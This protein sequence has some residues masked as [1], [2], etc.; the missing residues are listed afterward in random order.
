[1]SEL[2]I[3]AKLIRLCSMML[4]NSCS[5]VG[6]DLSEPFETVRGFRQGDSLSCDLFNFLMETVLRKAAVH[7]NGT[8]F[9]KSVQLL[10][11]DDDIDYIWRIM[12]DVTAAYSAIE[13]ESAVN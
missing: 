3:N 2:G 6:K 5:K 1:M 8:I 7:R 4:S 9:Y 10:A 12:R 13:R 11:Y